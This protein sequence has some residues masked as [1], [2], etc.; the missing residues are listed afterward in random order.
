MSFVLGLIVAFLLMT[1]AVVLASYATVSLTYW[2]E[3][4]RIRP[5]STDPHLPQLVR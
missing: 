2:F 5:V 4:R 3:S 1:A